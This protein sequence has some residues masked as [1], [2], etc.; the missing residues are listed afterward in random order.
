MIHSQ[1][2]F[3]KILCFCLLFIGSSALFGQRSLT[4]DL[5]ELQGELELTEDQLTQIA[6]LQE[7]MKTE[8]KSLRALEREERRTQMKSIRSDFQTAVEAILT[9]EQLAAVEDRRAEARERWEAR[10][11]QNKAMAEEVKNHKETEVQP[12]LLAQRAKLEAQITDA[13]KA[14]IDQLRDW[15]A[16]QKE[17]LKAERMAQREEQ[18]ARKAEGEVGKARKKKHKKGARKKDH[19]L[20]FQRLKNDEEH[21]A[22]ADALV[23][24]YSDEIDALAEEIADDQERWKAER[25][26]IA[27]KYITEEQRERMKNKKKKA[28]SNEASR[29]ELKS[30]YKK[31]GFILMEPEAGEASTTTTKS[32]DP[33]QIRLYPNPAISTQ[34]LEFRTEQAGTVVVEMID[35]SGNILRTLYSGQMEAGAHSLQVDVQDLRGQ[36]FY[37]RIKDEA[38][39]SSK[40]FMVNNN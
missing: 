38:G 22:I 15:L 19:G 7:E 12:V 11:A 3:I 10:R 33:H 20:L 1:L 40:Q 30:Y 18:K 37:Y 14:K 8:M 21:A 35:K 16:E 27:D 31:L 2:N 28:K 26:A 4:K 5:S 13:D 39:V 34:T 24:N 36:V 29:D 32:D 6:A 9:T 23:D 25:K 17:A